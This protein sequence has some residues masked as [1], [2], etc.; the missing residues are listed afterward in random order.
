MTRLVLCCGAS[1]A[2]G[3]LM[4]D[5]C[6]GVLRLKTA[7]LQVAPLYGGLTDEVCCALRDAVR[8][9]VGERPWAEG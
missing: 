8:Q 2:F 5:F 1:A 7:G 3:T 6:R 9:R 4:K